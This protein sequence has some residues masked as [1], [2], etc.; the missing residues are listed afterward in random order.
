VVNTPLI[1]SVSYDNSSLKLYKNGAA[2]GTAVSKSGMS[3]N[4]RAWHIGRDSASSSNYWNGYISEIIIYKR[5]ISL[6]DQS[7]VLEYL[8]D[9]WGVAL[10]DSSFRNHC[11]VGLVFRKTADNPEGKCECSDNTHVY[12][13]SVKA[14]DACIPQSVRNNYYGKCVSALKPPTYANPPTS[15][16][17][18]LWLDARDCTSIILDDNDKVSQWKDKSAP[19]TNDNHVNQSTE[20]SRPLYDRDGESGFSH[21][22]L[23]F[24][25]SN[26]FMLS[27]NNIPPKTLFVVH[28]S[29]A[30]SQTD[31]LF[32]FRTSVSNGFIYNNSSSADVIGSNW[33]SRYINGSSGGTVFSG[34]WQIAVFNGSSSSQDALYLGNAYS[35]TSTLNGKIA[36]VIA[37]ST[38][39]NVATRQ[40][41]EK[42]LSQKWGVS[43][44]QSV[45][46]PG[47][48]CSGLKLWLDANDPNDDT[49]QPS[50]GAAV[51]KWSDRS[52]NNNDFSSGDDASFESD[53]S[54]QINS[55]PVVHFVRDN[56]DNA[57]GDYLT[58]SFSQ[59]LNGSASTIIMALEVNDHQSSNRTI[60]SSYGGSSLKKGYV[61]RANSSNEFELLVGNGNSSW[62]SLTSGSVSLGKTTLVTAKIKSGAHSFSVNRATATTSSATYTRETSAAALLGAVSNSS[63]GAIERI[64]ADIAELILYNSE[65]SSSNVTAVEDYLISKW[66][67][68]LECPGD[69]CDNMLMWFDANKA[70]T[71]KSGSDCTGSVS[72]DGTVG[73]WQDRTGNGYDMKQATSSQRPVYKTSILN[74]KPIIRFDGSNDVL[75]TGDMSDT[76]AT[77]YTFFAVYKDTPTTGY[78][79]YFFDNEAEILILGKW[80][81][82]GNKIQ[83]NNGNS[84]SS[85]IDDT[86]THQIVTFVL[87]GSSDGRIYMNGALKLD[88]QSY[89]NRKIG[90]TVALGGRWSTSY[91]TYQNGDM[92]EFIVYNA[93]LNDANRVAVEES[94]G[95]KWGIDVGEGPAGV[96]GGLQLWLNANDTTTLFTNTGCTT[97]ASSSNNIACWK[98]KSNNGNH[99]TASGY[100][101][102]YA[103]DAL[104]SKKGLVFDGTEYLTSTNDSSITGNANLSVIITAKFDDANSSKSDASLFG[105]GGTAAGAAAILGQT[106]TSISTILAGFD[107]GGVKVDNPDSDTAAKV[108]SW[109]RS[110]ATNQRGEDHKIYV[111]GLYQAFTKHSS[112][113]GAVSIATGKYRVGSSPDGQTSKS[114]ISEVAVYNKALTN[115]DR[116][117]IE[118]EMGTRWGITV[119][120]T[121][122]NVG[123]DGLQLWLDANDGEYAFTSNNC[124]G[125]Y[126]SGASIGCW[127]DKSSSG[128]NA[129]NASAQPTYTY[130]VLNNRPVLDFTSDYLT[131]ASDDV[132][133]FPMTFFIVSKLD[134]DVGASTQ[135]YVLARQN[136]A[137]QGGNLIRYM[138]ASKME[139][140][141]VGSSSAVYS[142][143]T[144]NTSKNDYY[145]FTGTADN[146]T[147][148][149][150][151]LY[152]NGTL[153][154]SVSYSNYSNSTSMSATIGRR[155]D[156]NQAYLDGRIAEIIIYNSALSSSDRQN[157]HS[158]LSSKW[159]LPLIASYPGGVSEDIVL[160]LDGD[161]PAGTG[162]KPA[163]G[164]LTTWKDRINGL[165]FTQSTSSRRPT[166][167]G[168]GLNGKGILDFTAGSDH[169]LKASGFDAL[170]SNDKHSIFFVVKDEALS[171]NGHY[172]T[173]YSGSNSMIHVTNRG[174]YITKS[175]R[176]GLRIPLSNSGGDLDGSSNAL[177]QY[178]FYILSITRNAG[179]HTTFIN[180]VQESQTTSATTNSVPTTALDICLSGNLCTGAR[181]IDGQMAEIIIYNDALST[182]DRGSV[183]TYLSEKW[184]ITKYVNYPGGKHEN[185]VLWYDAND[186]DGDG[187]TDDNP[188][189]A[190]SISSWTDKSVN[191]NNASTYDSAPTYSTNSLNSKNTVSFVRTSVQSLRSARSVSATHLFA[192]G[193]FSSTTNASTLLGFDYTTNRYAFSRF[194]SSQFYVNTAGGASYS[195]HTADTNW[196][197]YSAK[198]TTSNAHV[199]RDGSDLTIS[200]TTLAAQ[201][202]KMY[203]GRRHNDGNYDTELN[204]GG[205]IA[206]VILY[207]TALSD[208][209][210]DAVETY[211]SN[212]WNI[213][214]P[215]GPGGVKD[216]LKLWLDASD[217]DTVTTVSGVVSLWEDK[218]TEGSDFSQST[219]SKRPTLDSSTYSKDTISFDGSDDYLTGSRTYSNETTLFIVT[220]KSSGTSDYIFGAGASGGAIAGSPAIITE[221]SSV[222]LEWFHDISPGDQD[223]ETIASDGKAAS[224]LHLITVRQ[225]D[226]SNLIARFNGAQKFSKT[227]VSSM[228]GK[229]IGY[230]GSASTS[231]GYMNGNIA[232]VALYHDA[233]S[234][235]DV[236]TVEAALATKWGI[237][238][239]GEPPSGNLALWL[240]ASD[241]STIKSAS[242][243]TGSV[244]NGGTIGCW[245]DKSGNNYHLSQATSSS[246]PVWT[247]NAFNS[248]AAITFDGSNDFFSRS[249]SLTAY[250]IF[251]VSKRDSTSG[252]GVLLGFQTNTRY[253]GYYGST[254]YAYTGGWSRIGYTGNALNILSTNL[255]NST[256]YI[257]LNGVNQTLTNSGTLGALSGNSYIGRRHNSGSELYFDGK[258]AEMLVYSSTLSS[259][260]KS[261]AIDYLKNKWGL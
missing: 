163:D 145:I 175:F 241:S 173:M 171:N 147:N 84:W 128:Y 50:D 116:E 172:M 126:S 41:I 240:D 234:D 237:T 144:S 101:P 243:C 252:T 51:S 245:Q 69:V 180:G 35:G 229:S 225:T 6:T 105:W 211:L 103:A 17:L 67:I 246:R 124:T 169:Q 62:N 158:Y 27:T 122:G 194:S 131:F 226:S 20:E 40:A 63:G 61:I 239:G 10:S 249:S 195:S 36:E 22:F 197:V 139:F 141:T 233:L 118:A 95:T 102:H 96:V 113:S 78:S 216:N 149:T 236:D 24:D 66:N 221:Y 123:T 164:A 255:V 215:T 42:Y 222:D 238:L 72:A 247:T 209:D 186:I 90:G 121:P 97:A 210:R 4:N 187:K 134:T 136:S 208:T 48:V 93:A 256:K 71:I 232:E 117:K 192:V 227:P 86:D 75:R 261:D 251:V 21:P 85:T 230:L 58:K 70:S 112:D 162:T 11:P 135:G 111:N 25:G 220:E 260:D 31:Y 200:D 201:T 198:V 219:S 168:D 120:H 34:S 176:S 223:R 52:G 153:S 107:T 185:L 155:P 59:N 179:T 38:S 159:A 181:P 182:T 106:G 157:V 254:T 30:S 244:S 26:D 250:E 154:Q 37:Y 15:T 115:A 2:V 47:S 224:G 151:S 3:L 146:S 77:P 89:T 152:T 167:D 156:Y 127:K 138:N 73:C 214:F 91:T 43:I 183:E 218:S 98:D 108:I 204:L 259:S 242:N 177:D 110:N 99:F 82:A 143:K 253:F 87:N 142:T 188:S 165:E 202:G 258:M 199:R 64:S 44:T 248:L 65:L 129:T 45:S 74:S 68:P 174:T 49:N 100:Q 18:K 54:S 76:S 203:L 130:N 160:W 161:D 170:A 56:S 13:S 178:G 148:G 12:I 133:N 119:Y 39:V 92:A 228:S 193:K 28:K 55:K 32:D 166:Y 205:N 140:V 9:K 191:R 150:L 46:C 83:F 19:G 114:R 189:N 190:T 33:S 206:E 125:S 79:G 217:S 5:Y 137:A 212:K 196:H 235:S 53:A 184:G 109:V 132:L 88:G 104:N 7:R 81:G 94:L 16:G 231:A 257:A 207:S 60:F 1:V 57:V 8:S 23:S 14:G 29:T 213:S 80:S